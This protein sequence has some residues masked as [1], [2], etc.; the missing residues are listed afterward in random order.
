MLVCVDDGVLWQSALDEKLAAIEQNKL[1]LIAVVKQ[2]SAKLKF[3][4]NGSVARDLDYVTTALQTSQERLASLN[5]ATDD[6][7]HVLSTSTSDCP[8]INVCQ[9]C[10]ELAALLCLQCFDAVFVGCQE[11]HPVC[12]KLSSDVLAWL[13]FWI[14]VEMICMWSS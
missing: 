6:A 14:K 7:V 11:E 9:L 12:K 3:T 5:A 10:S 13:S 2:T 8:E 1:N 4:L